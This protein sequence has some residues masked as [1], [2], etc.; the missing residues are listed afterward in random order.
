M[1]ARDRICQ[2]ALDLIERQA[3]AETPVA[4]ICRRAG[5]SNGSFFHAF[6]GRE[7][8]EAEMRLRLLRDHHDTV[9]A[10]L[11]D[12]RGAAEGIGAIIRAHVGW[13]VG[14][15]AKAEF[16]FRQGGAGSVAPAQH[17]LG[18]EHPR[19]REAIDGWRR[20]LT[21]SGG[22]ADLPRDVIIAQILGPVQ[23]CCGTWLVDGSARD[24]RELVDG[25]I[26]CAQRAL[27]RS[28]GWGWR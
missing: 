28:S 9:I 1:S 15:R 21:R 11:A 8:L 27:A 3:F 4:A 24:P 14:N 2:A 10:A 23:A 5:I 13:V 25:L 22:L 6:P 7:H 26:A 20:P 12:A 19:F 18:A 17:D 16:L